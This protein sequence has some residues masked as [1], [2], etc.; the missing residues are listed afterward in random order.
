MGT[1][2]TP[3]DFKFT[4]EEEENI[5]TPDAIEDMLLDRA[6]LLM[7][8][9][10]EIFGEKIMREAERVFLLQNV[11]THWMEHLDAMDDLK[12]SIGLNAYAQRN[13]I[14]EYRIA[15]AEM[16]DEMTAEIRESTVRMILAFVP[17][18]HQEIK[19]VQVAKITN[20]GLSGSAEPEKK[21]PV[22]KK[23]AEK[24][25]RNDPC[26]CGSGKKY[27]KCC[28]ASQVGDGE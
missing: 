24:V 11:D 4:K 18:Q 10:E 12:G 8:K 16:F 15:S 5:V 6:R 1:L 26:P 21:K 17:R 7:S 19:R 3:D 9:K 27:K 23:A 14:S 2:C 25:G 20:A 22:V 13:P 28:G